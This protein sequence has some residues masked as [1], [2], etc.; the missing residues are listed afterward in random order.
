VVDAGASAGGRQATLEFPNGNCAARVRAAGSDIAED[1]LRDVGLADRQRPVIVVCGGA[2]ELDNR[3]RRMSRA[4]NVLG[5]AVLRA[6]RAHEAAIVDGGTRSGVM[7]IVGEARGPG[8][9]DDD[10]LVGVAP[11]GRVSE[12][13]GQRETE[14]VEPVEPVEPSEPSEPSE[15]LEPLEPLEPHHTHFVLADSE[16][17]GGET[18][19]LFRVADA[20]SD[21]R[22]AV[23][24]LSGGGN[25]RR[26]VLEAVRR[27]WPIVVVRGFG[28][29]SR[30]LLV[31]DRVT[32][33]V[34]WLGLARP[35]GW[36]TD[37]ISPDLHMMIESKT[38]SFFRG[39]SK[40]LERWIAWEFADRHALKGVWRT[41]AAYD[42]Q[43]SVLQTIFRVSQMAIIAVGILATALATFHAWAARVDEDAA[44]LLTTIAPAIVALLIALGTRRAFGKRWILLRAA[45]ESVK[46]ET[47]RYRTET[48]PYRTGR[49]R[50]AVLADRIA[51]IRAQLLA[52]E[53][54]GGRLSYARPGRPPALD[55]ESLAD[56][57]AADYAR[58][59]TADQIG[60]YHKAVRRKIRRR[61]FLQWVALAVGAAGSV[62][63]ALGG[64]PW[65]ALTTAV[66]AGAA[67]YLATRQHEQDVL[68]YNQAAADLASTYD[69]WLATSGDLATEPVGDAVDGLLQLT[70]EGTLEMRGMGPVE[71]I[72]DGALA[73][74]RNSA[75]ANGDRR[76]EEDAK[77]L[78]VERT[79]TILTDE[80]GAWARRMARVL[81]QEAK[82]QR[83]HAATEA[84]GAG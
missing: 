11:R 4:S 20:L 24:L 80:V 5:P 6:A 56:L 13:G 40:A 53:A 51:A 71:V 79:E 21:A 67:S 52:T 70:G 1:L 45:A 76:T 81:E 44:R 35:A 18:E 47:Y 31:A 50:D 12:P 73:V 54:A 39:G 34:R 68:I 10:V 63:A 74:T 22:K 57:G 32:R 78:L 48:G 17:W 46:T 30:T 72:C 65:V 19:L 75:E 26:E 16:Q 43:A 42:T 7:R 8:R 25:A 55:D 62:I 28:G 66:S 29:F 59:R 60:Y 3:R 38:I 15:P 82:R 58:H 49:S 23:V 27:E 77:E 84:D 41:F 9:A 64:E 33:A 69:E 36:L 61:N 37:R 2:K 83:E 14:P